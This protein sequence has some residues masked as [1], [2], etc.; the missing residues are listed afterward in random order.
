MATTGEA[1]HGFS[2]VAGAHGSG[3][4]QVWRSIIISIIMISQSLWRSDE[5]LW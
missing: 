3:W 2:L 5:V 4:R 1:E